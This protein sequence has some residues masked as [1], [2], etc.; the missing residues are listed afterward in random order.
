[1]TQDVGWPFASAVLRLVVLALAMLIA[2]AVVAKEVH[3]R[4]VVY[5]GDQGLRVL[6]QVVREF[7]QAHPGIEVSLENVPYGSYFQ[8]L[9]AQ[10]AANVA[11]DVAMMD[12]VN[13][14]EALSD[15]V[16]VDIPEADYPKVQTLEQIVRYVTAAPGS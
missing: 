3:L 1:M 8:K 6:R 14:L 2:C 9:L 5:D 4:F 7:E 11:P 12:F 13:F 10:Y 16:G 15:R